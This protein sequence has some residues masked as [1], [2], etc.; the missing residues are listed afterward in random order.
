MVRAEMG[1]TAAALKLL[2]L[3]LQGTQLTRFTSTK[4]QILTP[5]AARADE[6]LLPGLRRLARSFTSTK[7][8]IL[9]PDAARARERLVPGLRRLAGRA[10]GPHPHR[11]RHPQSV[12]S[13]AALDGAALKCWR[14]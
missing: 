6:R 13:A 7:V 8:Q 11:C 10:Q 14:S 12:A 9:T 2:Q 1:H 5:E 4:V 3:G